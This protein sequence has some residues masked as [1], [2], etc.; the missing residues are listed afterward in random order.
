MI[1]NSRLRHNV[2]SWWG[3]PEV[4][5]GNVLRDNCVSGGPRDDGNGGINTA[6]GGFIARS[7]RA[8]APAFVN[9]ADKDFRLAA[10]SPCKSLHGASDAVP[11]VGGSAP[12]T[13]RRAARPPVL[14]LRVRPGVVRHGRRMR[15]RGHADLN[16]VSA[17]RR[18]TIVARG[19]RG[20]HVI[21]RIKVRAGGR[22]RLSRRLRPH[23]RT[24]R[25]VAVVRGVGRSRA[26]RLRVRR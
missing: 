9:R 5:R 12:V 26:V 1:T 14:R 20:R 7:N 8:A 6:D 2:E 10:H 17:G 18:V 22:F 11:G 4:G 23:G 21:G 15:I 19:K 24:V 3:G 13:A 25:L 16:R